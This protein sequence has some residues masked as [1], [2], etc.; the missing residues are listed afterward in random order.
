MQKFVEVTLQR[1]NG[2]HVRPSWKSKTPFLHVLRSSWRTAGENV[3]RTT[4]SWGMSRSD[5]EEAAGPGK[6]GEVV[7]VWAETSFC[8]AD[9]ETASVSR[10]AKQILLVGSASGISQTDRWKRLGVAKLQRTWRCQQTFL[11]TRAELGH[12]HL[13]GWRG[14]GVDTNR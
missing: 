13:C 14:A 3:T 6:D 12:S 2:S 10:F 11:F 4:S 8:C 1:R 9:T 7:D 5:Q